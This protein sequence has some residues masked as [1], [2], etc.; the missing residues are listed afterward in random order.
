MRC[1]LTA[2]ALVL[3]AAPGW[4]AFDT[5]EYRTA[6]YGA[7]DHYCDPTRSLASSGS[8]TLGD[9]WN[10]TQCQTQ[11]VCG[12]VIGLLPVGGGTPVQIPVSAGNYN[13]PAFEPSGI[14]DCTLGNELVYVAKYA[15][16]ALTR[17]TITTDPNRTEFRT[18]GVAEA[19]D[20]VGT[21]RAAYGTY[22][23]D[24]VIYDGIFVDMAQVGINGD[25]GIISVFNATGVK[26][27]NFRIKGTTTDMDS[28]PIVYRPG[29]AT[30]TVLSNFESWDFDNAPTGGGLNQNGIWSD[31]YG[32]H[33]YLIEHFVLDNVD[34]GLFAKG[35]A[36]GT[37]NYGTIRYGVIKNVS[38]CLAFND[39]DATNLTTV[40]YVL[41][42]GW[43]FVGV[44]LENQTSVSRN[45]LMHHVTIANGPCSSSVPGPFYLR[46]G[47][48]AVN[49]GWRDN[50]LDMLNGGFCNGVD[51]GEFTGTFPSGTVD[52]N[53]YYKAGAT[54]TW[55]LNGSSYNT[56]GNWRTA[57][58][59]EASSLVLASDP[60]TNRAGSDFTV[61]VGHAAKTAS[62]TGGEIGAYAGSETVGYDISSGTVYFPR[63]RRFRPGD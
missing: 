14:T 13:E 47:V 35:T 8:G 55:S 20:I 41:C 16:I 40:E 58:G 9:P 22:D 7:P 48:S 32:D 10:L 31:Q 34:R 30:N 15:A 1:L 43:S 12:E 29:N 42:T 59:K 38:Q 39:F 45:F 11:P 18:D 6:T 56:I 24:Y 57:T 62:S 19:A 4:A 25:Q 51:A 23:H 53:G 33:N 2:A 26:F 44:T 63:F 46:N 54:V 21:G 36:A 37:F 27:L 5:S 3:L 52:Y 28:N 17:A 61:A 49:V 50:I 60:F